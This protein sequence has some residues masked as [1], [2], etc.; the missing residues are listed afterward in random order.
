MS[1]GMRFRFTLAFVGLAIG[2]LIVAGLVIN[3]LSFNLLE[4]QSLSSQKKTAEAVGSKIKHFIE[5]RTNDLKMLNEVHR[6][7][8]ISSQEQYNLL[9]KILFIERIFQ[10]FTLLDENGNERIRLSRS[11]VFLEAELKNRSHEEEYIYPI[12]RHE[13]YYGSI[14]FDKTISEP[15]LTVSIP[16]CDKRTGEIVS[17]LI[18]ELRFKGIWE[19]LARTDLPDESDVYVVDSGG[20]VIAHRNP[21]LVLSGT[22]IDLPKEDGRAVGLKDDIAFISQ[23]TLRFGE[24]EFTIV[25]EQ[26]VFSALRLAL[27]NRRISYVVIFIALIS[28]LFVS[29]LITPYLLNPVK[30]LL[31]AVRLVGEGNLSQ[32]V[33]ILNINKKMFLQRMW[34]LLIRK[35][36]IAIQKLKGKKYE[37]DMSLNELDEIGELAH[38]F[39]LMIRRLRDR[40]RTIQEQQIAL[41]AAHKELEDKVRERTSKL[42]K[43]NLQ[44]EREI[45]ERKRIEEELLKSQ[46]LESLGVL[47]G[48]IAHDFNN[49]LMAILGNI[50]IAKMSVRDTE[51][52]SRILDQAEKATQRASSLTHQLLTF[53]KGG[54]PV[55]ELIKIDEVLRESAGFA[56]RGSNISCEFELPDNLRPL[57]ADKGQITQVI[58]NLIINAKQAMLNGGN[59]RIYAE[60]KMIYSEYHLPV[61]DG[62]YMMFAIED[63]GVGIPMEH[64]TQ[65]FDPYF[66]T[67]G[68]GSG[69][70]LATSYSIVKKHNGHIAVES[71][72][73]EGTTFFVYL[74]ISYEESHTE[75]NEQ[76][77]TIP[78]TGRILIMDDEKPVREVLGNMLIELGYTVEFAQNGE[79]AVEQYSQAKESGQRFDAV[80]LDLTVKKGMG[81]KE[82]IEK[83]INIDPETKGIVS[84]GYSNDPIMSHY[85]DH[86]FVG[87]ITKPYRLQELSVIMHDVLTTSIKNIL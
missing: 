69:L 32:E 71:K 28:A 54:T 72:E 43:A 76:E 47:A 24:Q 78:G 23:K 61:P 48:G 57:I 8:T 53:S 56:L 29:V 62:E 39:N 55:K 1:S 84:S 35:L 34:L 7:G 11:R 38:S 63:H 52:L 15:L 26:S 75:I 42:V 20:Y 5:D 14:Q 87:V 64:I 40:E 67:K 4:Q 51:K 31:K 79:E 60:Y 74:P 21:T 50:S 73:G 12:D 10:E 25:A 3:R 65:I 49:I 44:L 59:I 22:R 18:A 36:S 86:G 41:K 16:L 82:S 68:N 85:K 9:S 66:T 19:I 81:G 13:I 46:K 37:V 58:H 77:S 70:G 17:I 2:P 30:K 27:L 45:S 80:I 83:L 33:E 6:L